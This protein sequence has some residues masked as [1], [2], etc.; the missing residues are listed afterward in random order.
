MAMQP[1]QHP[2]ET[3]QYIRQVPGEAVRDAIVANE[4]DAEPKGRTTQ[5]QAEIL[6]ADSKGEN[7]L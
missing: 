4:T 2:A 1:R 5:M 3:P 7:H 6:P